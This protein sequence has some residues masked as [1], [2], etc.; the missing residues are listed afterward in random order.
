MQMNGKKNIIIII[1]I[2]TYT[3]TNL[4]QLASQ[5]DHK[6]EYN[7]TITSLVVVF[8]VDSLPIKE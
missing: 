5:Q 2:T 7:E 4:I 1:T 8:V 3:I 6:K